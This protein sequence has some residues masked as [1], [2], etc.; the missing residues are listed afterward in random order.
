MERTSLHEEA[1]NMN[2][3]TSSWN[4]WGTVR[5]AYPSIPRPST[6]R[7]HLPGDNPKYSYKK[8]R[9]PASRKENY[10]YCTLNAST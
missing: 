1:A 7:Y 8:N 2:G 5:D 6:L 10:M 9:F 4:E 3:W